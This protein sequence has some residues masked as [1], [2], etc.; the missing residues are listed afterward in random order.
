MTRRFRVFTPWIPARGAEGH[1][2]AVVV[3]GETPA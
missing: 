2:Y 1:P 3:A